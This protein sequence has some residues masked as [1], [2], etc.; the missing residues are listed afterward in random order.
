MADLPLEILRQLRA[1]IAKID[2]RLTD[3]VESMHRIQEDVG[4]LRGS[5]GA[6]RHDLNI[7][8]ERWR[9]LEVRVRALEETR[10]TPS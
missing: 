7:L 6:A 1:D 9:D 8:N 4:A 10:P 5:S 3:M 2:L